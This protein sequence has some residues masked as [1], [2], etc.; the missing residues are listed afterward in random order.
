M[1]LTKIKGC[2]FL[3]YRHISCCTITR[4]E[5]SVDEF[6]VNSYTCSLLIVV[7]FTCSLAYHFS[8]N[9]L[10][11]TN[12]KCTTL[13]VVLHMILTLKYRRAYTN[14]IPFFPFL[15]RRVSGLR[16][17]SKLLKRYYNIYPYLRYRCYQTLEYII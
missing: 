8:H 3:V 7:V 6:T 11:C 17:S 14:N 13:H 15:F 16:V 9:I 4:M 5:T 12:D 10:Q 2:C 1:H